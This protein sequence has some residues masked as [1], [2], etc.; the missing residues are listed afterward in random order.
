VDAAVVSDER[1]WKEVGV[2]ARRSEYDMKEIRLFGWFVGNE[3]VVVVIVVVAVVDGEGGWEKVLSGSGGGR[4]GCDQGR[5]H[6]G[7]GCSRVVV[8]ELPLSAT[9]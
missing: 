6:E 2:E 3:V 7:G 8:L 5:E 4:G 1:R 9:E